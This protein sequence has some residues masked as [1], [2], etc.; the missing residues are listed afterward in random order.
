MTE[1]QRSLRQDLIFFS[2]LGLLGIGVCLY[3]HSLG[4]M[5]LPIG[6]SLGRVV[7]SLG[8]MKLKVYR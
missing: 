2:I 8:Y 5:G 3:T 4:A 1:K 7:S 6:Y